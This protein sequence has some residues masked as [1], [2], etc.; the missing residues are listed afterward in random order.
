MD[1]K[2]CEC[3]YVFR[4]G[5]SVRWPHVCTGSQPQEG[6]AFCNTSFPMLCLCGRI[7]TNDDDLQTH[8]CPT[9]EQHFVQ[10][11]HIQTDGS[12]RAVSPGPDRP[13][14]D[15]NVINVT[16]LR[17]IMAR[18]DGQ[19]LLAQHKA[20]STR[21]PVGPRTRR[22]NGLPIDYTDLQQKYTDCIT[23]IRN[24]P[25]T[26]TRYWQLHAAMQGIS[27]AAADRILKVIRGAFI[28]GTKR[29]IPMT[30]TIRQHTRTIMGRFSADQRVKCRGTINLQHHGI[31]GLNDIDVEFVHPVWGWIQAV[32]TSHE[33]LLLLLTRLFFTL[34]PS[35]ATP[36]RR[37]LHHGLCGTHAASE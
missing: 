13:V 32:C 19:T 14:P 33:V 31:H 15:D 4:R 18:D 21:A 30:T 28:T 1:V 29:E 11:H 34:R 26:T 22:Q 20:S 37:I 23:E 12:H 6:G 24:L 2:T 16:T 27:A 25:H 5:Q 7:L 3:G 10:D 35:A 8:R 9:H 36:A 17:D